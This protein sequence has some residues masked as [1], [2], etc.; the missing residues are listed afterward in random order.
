MSVSCSHSFPSGRFFPKSITGA[1]VAHPPVVQAGEIEAVTV[2][3]VTDDALGAGKNNASDVELF[4]A[5]A[6]APLQL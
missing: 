4:L 3:M 2:Q 6:L 5:R 1:E